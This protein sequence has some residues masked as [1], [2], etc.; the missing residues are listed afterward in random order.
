MADRKMIATD[1]NDW[2]VY[3]K[4]AKSL[5]K[6]VGFKVYVN[7][8]VKIMANEYINNHPELRVKVN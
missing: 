5:S 7:N 4:I 8:A 6:Q 1:P 2:K 3:D